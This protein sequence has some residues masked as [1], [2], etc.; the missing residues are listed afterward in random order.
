M[1]T[2]HKPTEYEINRAACAHFDDVID[3][4]VDWRGR[5]TADVAG[6]NPDAQPR[7]LNEWRILN[8]DTGS[9]R[10]LSGDAGDGPDLISLVAHLGG[11]ERPA[12]AEL[13]ASFV[14]RARINSRAA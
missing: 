2:A 6:L 11:V 10:S 4:I 12:A 3:L 5:P 7:R 14:E 9:W 8:Q 1:T 13:L